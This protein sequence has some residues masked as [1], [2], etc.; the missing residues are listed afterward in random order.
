M[1]PFSTIDTIKE[2][3]NEITD[4]AIIENVL[5]LSGSTTTSLPTEKGK[6]PTFAVV[7]DSYDTKLKITIKR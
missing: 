6:A 4:K 2:E 7:A 5:K 1:L 3:N